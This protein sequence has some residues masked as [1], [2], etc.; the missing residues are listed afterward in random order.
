MS[1]YDEFLM[2]TAAIWSV[3]SKAKRKQVGAVIAYDNRIISTGF[4]GTLPGLPNECEDA[5]GKTLPTVM[6]AEA[7]AILFAAR[8]GLALDG[9]TIYTTLSPCVQCS[10]M[11]AGAGITRVV[12]VKPHSDTTGLDL[13]ED[14]GVDVE[15]INVEY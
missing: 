15:Q 3:A 4:N 9:C 1:K 11:I 8:E 12:Y 6:H 13:L 5:A 7:N 10:K 2:A 14:C